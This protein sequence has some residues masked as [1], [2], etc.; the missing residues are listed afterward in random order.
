MKKI[1]TLFKRVFDGH[2]L[3]DTTD[4]VNK[5]LEWVLNGDGIATVKY[6]GACCAIIDGVFYKRYDAKKGKRIPPE[7]IRCQEQ[8]DPVTGHMP[9]WV[10]VDERK[11]GDKWFCSAIKNC[12]EE[13]PDGTY[14]AVGKHF[15]GNPYKLPGDIL[16]RHGEH[17]IEVKRSFEGIRNWL[18]NHNAEGI[19]FWKDG[20]PMCKIKRKD[21][22]LS[23]P[24]SQAAAPI[25]ES[26]HVKYK[27]ICEVCGKVEILTADEAFDRGWDYPPRMYSFGVVS[28]RTCGDCSIDKTL[29]WKL[30]CEKKKISELGEKEL[31]TLERITGEPE[32]IIVID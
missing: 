8:P 24:A 18:E 9:C 31:Q 28:P 22:G 11:A 4:E 3:V 5:E 21:F 13:L 17:V 6:D 32:R 16:V 2:L 12:R 20:I 14:E 1:P 25:L 26:D 10:K 7:A 27:C 30:M 23:W 29:W 19:V 15:Q